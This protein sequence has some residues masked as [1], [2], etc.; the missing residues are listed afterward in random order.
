MA[1]P[2]Q[3]MFF[4]KGLEKLALLQ[5]AC[6]DTT[7]HPVVFCDLDYAGCPPAEELAVGGPEDQLLSTKVTTTQFSIW[8]A[9]NGFH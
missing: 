5:Q 8:L 1:A 7:P 6:L 9:L 3:F 2:N 4:A